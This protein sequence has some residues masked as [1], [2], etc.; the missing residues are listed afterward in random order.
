MALTISRSLLAAVIRH[1]QQEQPWEAC[2]MLAGTGRVVRRA[3][4]MRNAANS[5]VCYRIDA[6]EQA[7]VMDEIARRG[8]RLLAIYHSHPTAPAQPSRRDIEL[9]A[10]RDVVYV[11][12]SLRR[13][14]T[15]RGFY[16]KDGQ[17]WPEFIRVLP[18]ISAPIGHLQPVR[19]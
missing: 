10:Y 8:E 15:V 11:I 6:R 18:K 9:A 12:I 19:I 1:C 17:A 2:G 3:F 14:V 13:P 5:P 4:H 16:I 7:Q